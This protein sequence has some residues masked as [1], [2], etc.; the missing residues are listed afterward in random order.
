MPTS[1]YINDDFLGTG[2]SFPPTFDASAQAVQTTSKMDDIQA[3][4]QILLTTT[5]GERIMEPKFGCNMADLIFKPV[6]TTLMTIIKDRV[7][8]AVLYFESR[9]NVLDVKLDISN[10]AGGV[11]LVTVTYTVKATNSRFN[12][13][14]PYYID[15]GSELEFLT[16]NNP[17]AS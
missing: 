10:I 15:E 2:W 3:S 11:I 9:I 13:V 4:L 8:T 16:T 5:P 14:Y 6:N 12:F 17:T 7:E 1:N